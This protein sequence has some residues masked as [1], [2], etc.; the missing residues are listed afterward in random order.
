MEARM[1]TTSTEIDT[2]PYTTDFTISREAMD[3]MQAASNY[4]LK[5]RDYYGVSS[6]RYTMAVET[7]QRQIT[8]VFARP[9]GAGVRVMKDN[10]LSLVVSA[11]SGFVFGLIF[12]GDKRHCT[13]EGCMA[14]INDDGTTSKYRYDS[15]ECTD[16]KH[17]PSYPLDAPQPGTWSFH[18]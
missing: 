15:P 16:G 6:K 17:E 5:L 3:V 10:D 11:A 14:F 12:H 9:M 18:S 8:M 13:R 4:C 1:T 2:R 7:W